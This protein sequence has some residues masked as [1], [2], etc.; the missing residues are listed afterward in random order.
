MLLYQ[1]ICPIKFPLNH[2]NPIKITLN[3]Y[4]ISLKSHYIPVKNP[5]KSLYP[6]NSDHVQVGTAVV[7]LPRHRLDSSLMS[8]GC[9]GQAAAPAATSSARAPSVHQ[10]SISRCYAYINVFMKNK[11]IFHNMHIYIHIYG[12]ALF[13]H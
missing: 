1:R 13:I 6:I 9:S 7:P 12:S 3:H 11:T 2:Y 5:I 10:L 8:P 4:K